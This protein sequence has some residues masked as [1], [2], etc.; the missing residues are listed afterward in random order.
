MRETIPLIYY[1]LSGL[2]S[3]SAE[4]PFFLLIQDNTEFSYV[5]DRVL[6][7]SSAAENNGEEYVTT[8]TQRYNDTS[9][10]FPPSMLVPLA[11]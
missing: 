4:K 9:Y 5:Q 10:H 1:Y 8:G 11:S 3:D 2:V 7:D 6:N